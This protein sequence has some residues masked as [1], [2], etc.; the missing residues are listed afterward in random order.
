MAYNQNMVKFC[1]G[2]SQRWLKFFK[3][4]KILKIIDVIIIITIYNSFIHSFFL[5][6]K[7][8]IHLL[9]FKHKPITKQAYINW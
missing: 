3:N 9:I 8:L 4:L 1:Y 2:W 5:K 7:M 6:W